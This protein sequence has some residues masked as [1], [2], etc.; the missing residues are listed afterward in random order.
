MTISQDQ[1]KQIKFQQYQE[2]NLNLRRLRSHFENAM[3]R[4]D[5]VSFVDI[6]S[7]LRNWADMAGPLV[8][9][10]PEF[11][12]R[13]MFKS[14]TPNRATVRE[15]ANI[16][17]VL[18]LTPSVLPTGMYSPPPDSR[19]GSPISG[20]KISK[21]SRLLKNGDGPFSIGG[22]NTFNNKGQLQTSNP[23]FVG[24][25][26][27]DDYVKFGESL[28]RA[29]V[30][31][32]NFRCWMGAEVVRMGYL[33]SKD[34]IKVVIISRAMLISRVANILNG[35]HPTIAIKEQNQ[36]DPAVKI[37]LELEFQGV[38]LP[39]FVLFKI[40]EDILHFAPK[41]FENASARD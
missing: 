37:L 4:F 1:D 27:G 41:Y 24:K 18:F 25:A 32:L 2:I 8:R 10:A 33:D 38:P 13:Q 9:I 39:F 3:Q 20:M 35:S 28:Q 23:Y 40:A 26:L 21:N 7:S 17:Y 19:Q 16:T 34:N 31:P 14:A 22:L 12:S 11:S 15:I 6:A 30:K 36:Y 29:S 5:D